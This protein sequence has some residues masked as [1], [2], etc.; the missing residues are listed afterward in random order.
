MSRTAVI[1]VAGAVFALATV[2][3][4]GCSTR[5]TNGVDGGILRAASPPSLRRAV[6]GATTD[7]PGGLRLGSGKACSGRQVGPAV[8][9]GDPDRACC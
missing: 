7:R 5:R 3:R 2:S 8:V 9:V 1:A 4:V 6:W